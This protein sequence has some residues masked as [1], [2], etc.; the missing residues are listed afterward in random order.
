MAEQPAFRMVEQDDILIIYMS[1][2]DRASVD[3]VLDRALQQA[4]ATTTGYALRVLVIERLLFP[5]PYVRERLQQTTR[6]VPE[7]LQTY[8][9]IILPQMKAL[10]AGYMVL[11]ALLVKRRRATVEAFR[12]L[13]DGLA[14]IEQCRPRIDTPTD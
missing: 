6:Q 3:A 8:T 5:T 7:T 4:L 13:E 14:W 12:T 10:W 1:N 11:R 2:L 9:A